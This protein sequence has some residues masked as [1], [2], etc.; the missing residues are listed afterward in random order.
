M[1]L[2]THIADNHQERIGFA[3]WGRKIGFAKEVTCPD[4][5]LL[6]LDPDSKIKVLRATT[7][8]FE[9]IDH[10]Y[11]NAVAGGRLVGCKNCL[12]KIRQAMKLEEE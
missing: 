6:R 4:P 9:N 8:V 10:W 11:L 7:F 2:I 12:G 3:L 1:S 5:D